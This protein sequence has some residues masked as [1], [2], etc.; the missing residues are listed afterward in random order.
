MEV[1]RAL[2]DRSRLLL[3]GKPSTGLDI[4]TRR[5]LVEEMHRL[6][7]EEGVAV[8]WATHLVDEVRSR[9]DLIVLEK[10]RMVARGEM[11]EVVARGGSRQSRRRLYPADLRTRG[12]TPVSPAHATR[13][14]SAIVLREALRF[15]QQKERFFAALMRLLIWLVVFAAGFRATL[16][17]SI[18][19]PY[20]NLHHL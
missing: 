9:D 20:Q 15:V 7:R 11:E 12:G 2:I 3:L 4:S 1:A 6:A 17:L 5:W 13:A 14:F 16:E 19:P 18:I 8:L 10:G